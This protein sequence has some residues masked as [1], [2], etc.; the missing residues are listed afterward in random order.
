MK[1]TVTFFDSTED[2]LELTGLSSEDELR[3]VGFDIDGME[4][5]FVSDA[6]WNGGWWVEQA[7]HYEHWLLSLMESHCVGYTHTS[8]R[9]KHYYILYH[10]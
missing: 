3:E 6:Q 9:S 8:L 1:S 2:L 10:W 4:F 7:T 5:G